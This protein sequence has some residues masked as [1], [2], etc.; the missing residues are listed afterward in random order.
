MTNNKLSF[1][2]DSISQAPHKFK[3]GDIDSVS[4]CRSET[5]L[6][7]CMGQELLL[8]LDIWLTKLHIDFQK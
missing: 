3:E 4:Q 1:K 2:L 6:K 5:I 7:E 8:Q